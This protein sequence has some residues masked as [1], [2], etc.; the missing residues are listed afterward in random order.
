MGVCGLMALIPMF[1]KGCGKKEEENSET[2]GGGLFLYRHLSNMSPDNH[3]HLTP[4]PQQA[5]GTCQHME[6]SGSYWQSLGYLWKALATMLA[7]PG[8]INWAHHMWPLVRY[9]LLE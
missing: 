5:N 4:C 9:P 2:S 6:A 8:A 3:H 1:L 7:N